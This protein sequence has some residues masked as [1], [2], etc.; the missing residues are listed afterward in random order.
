MVELKIAKPW[1]PRE[2]HRSEPGFREFGVVLILPA[3]NDNR[4]FRRRTSLWGVDVMLRNR[5]K[6]N[7]DC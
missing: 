5:S 4:F 6:D 3:V 7:R 2:E 1:L